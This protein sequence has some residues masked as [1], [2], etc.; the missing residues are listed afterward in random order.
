VRDGQASQTARRVAAQRRHFDRLTVDYGDPAGDQRLHDDVAGDLPFRNS[1]FALYLHARTRFFDAAVVDAAA[2]GLTQVVVVGAGY[3]GR[4]L[5]YAAPGAR[6]FEL[7]HPATTSDKAARLARLGLLTAAVAVPADFGA[8]DVAG[9][10]AAAGQ[11][12]VIPS[13]FYCEGVTPYL[14]RE[15]IARLLRALRT[16]AAPG[17]RLAIDVPLVPRGWRARRARARLRARVNA[18]GE[19]MRFQIRFADVPGL[20][21]EGGWQLERAADPAGADPAHSRR[22][23]AFVLASP[24][25]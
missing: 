16:R 11:D 23:T 22:P 7:D 6:W 14:E 18:Q 21:T 3:D 25:P 10:L 2:A 24:Y 17:S 12:A 20:L 15:S 13:L 8:D 1:P 19:P 4:S 9:R 5:R